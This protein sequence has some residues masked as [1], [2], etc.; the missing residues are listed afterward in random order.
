M[1]IEK[2]S[3]TFEQNFNIEVK[4]YEEKCL[5]QELVS[6]AKRKGAVQSQIAIQLSNLMVVQS[7][8]RKTQVLEEELIRENPQIEE[9]KITEA[10]DEISEMPQTRKVYSEEIKERDVKM[11]MVSERSKIHSSCLKRWVKVCESNLILKSRGKKVK[12]TE[13]K[14]DLLNFIKKKRG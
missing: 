13:L 10:V 1:E 3:Q 4:K 6:V 9:E 11:T 2:L 7:P 12:Y 8:K 14:E 5:D